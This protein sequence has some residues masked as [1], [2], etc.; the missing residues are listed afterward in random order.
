MARKSRKAAIQAAIDGRPL[1]TEHNEPQQVVWNAAGYVRLSIMETRDRK[2]SQAL[3]NQ[4]DMLRGYVER[5]ADLRLCG[6][7]ADNGETGTNFERSEFQHLMNDIQAGRVNCIVVKDLS[8][9]GRN[10]VEAGN[11]LERVFPFLGVR[12]ISVSDGYDS[13]APNAGDALAVAL[14]NL[15]NEAY[16]MDISRK[17]GSVLRE[18]QKRGEFIGAFAAYGYLKDPN[19]GHKLIV[20]P[21]AAPIVREIFRR[22]AG[23]EAV[24][25]ILRWLN[26]EGIPSPGV[27]RYQKG[28]CLDKRFADGT[29]KPWQQMP[30]KTILTNPVYLGHTVQGRKRAQFYAGIPQKRLPPSEWII[31]KNTHE[32]IVDQ[33]TFD[34]VQKLQQAA[35]EKYHAGIG[36]YDH[37]GVEENIFQGLVFCADCGRTMV[38]YKSVSHGKKVAYRFICPNY[39]NLVERSGCVYKYF[40]EEVLKTTLS[41]LIVQDAALAVDAAALLGK[42]QHKTSSLTDLEL[43][44]VKSEQKNLEMLRERLMRDLLSGIISKEDHDRMKQKYAQEAQTLDSRMAQLRKEQHREKNLLTARNP[45]LAA[46]RKHTE[47]LELTRELVQALVE[48]VTVYG[49]DRVEIQLKYRD[50][51]AELLD[52]LRQEVQ[53]VSA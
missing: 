18:K 5:Q 3:S 13:A 23:G 51:R 29:A 52:A 44:R 4:M 10:A 49:N 9:F 25:S 27:Y 12:F 2:D 16:S 22:A 41:Q 8:R 32:P 42:R 26:T 43:A 39:A 28:I 35:A 45:W 40:P 15:V 20:D 31:V 38:R 47:K 17:S 53:E 48:R 6:L 33:D 37:L 50:E 14:K 21:D 30:L 11:Y 1:L 34:Q 36:K 19:D 7:Y 24:R 46:F